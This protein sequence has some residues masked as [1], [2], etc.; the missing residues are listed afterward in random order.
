M[1]SSTLSKGGAYPNAENTLTSHERPRPNKCSFARAWVKDVVQTSSVF[2]HV[3][4]SNVDKVVDDF[5]GPMI[6]RAGTVVIEQGATV[7]GGEPG[8]FM[9]ES[10]KVE[11]FVVKASQAPPGTLVYTYEKRGQTFGHLAL[12]YDCPRSATVIAS[13][14]AVLWHISRDCFKSSIDDNHLQRIVERHSQTMRTIGF[15]MHSLSSEFAIYDVNLVDGPH[16]KE[17][18]KRYYKLCKQSNY[19][20]LTTSCFSVWHKNKKTNASG[21]VIPAIKAD[22]NEQVRIFFFDDNMEWDGKGNSPGISNLR[23]VETGDFVEFAEGS[24]GFKCEMV[25]ENSI[26]SYSSKYKNVLVQVNILDA[27]G[28]DDFFIKIINKYAHPDEK[29]LVFM[30]CNATIISSDSISGK[31]MSEVLLGTML[32]MMR[33]RPT[34]PFELVWDENRT[35]KIEKSMDLKQVVKLLGGNDN[36]FYTHFFTWQRC[37]RLFDLILAATEIVW[38]NRIDTSFS[39]DGFK[40]MYERYLISL[41]G[42]TDEHGITQSWYKLYTNLSAGGH[43]VILNSFGMDTRKVIART[44][45]DERQVL[46]VA[47]NIKL[48]SPKDTKSFE[49]T[50]GVSDTT[51]K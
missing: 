27:M 6:V 12:L 24:N 15:D 18:L 35:A 37:T 42:G 20:S 32:Q 23:D 39:L 46:M 28:D 38:A 22:S 1:S 45:L 36:A 7:A 4:D 26:A 47:A 11:V 8:L 2:M 29:V 5:K 44:V 43:S 21:K 51:A 3:A 50:Y 34:Q 10:G 30:D 16:T 49:A 19:L 31:G 41:V 25:S 17:N 40:D 9:L 14:N 33:V 13:T 48:W